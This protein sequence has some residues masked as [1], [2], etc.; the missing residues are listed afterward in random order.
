MMRPLRVPGPAGAGPGIP[1]AGGGS[2]PTGA[3]VMPD[4]LRACVLLSIGCLIVC[5][6]TSV[7]VAGVLLLFAFE[8]AENA[9]S[10]KMRHSSVS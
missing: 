3:S 2:L 5:Q 1:D 9:G 6:P 10:T 8:Q 4:G 7:N